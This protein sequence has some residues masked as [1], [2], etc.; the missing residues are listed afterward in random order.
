M[1]NKKVLIEYG[2]TLLI[3]LLLFSAVGLLLRAMLFEP[4]K[5]FESVGAFLGAEPAAGSTAVGETELI[6]SAA[7][8]CYVLVTTED[9]SHYAA[10]YDGANKEKLFSQ[11]SSYLGMALGSADAPE[12]ITESDFQQALEQSGVFFD[13]V[14]PQPLSAVASW[15][16]TDL[17]GDAGEHSA[18]RL[19]L[20]S[21]KDVLC[22]YYIDESDYAI[23]R[24]NTA[25]SFSSLAVK[26]SEMPIGSSALA[27]ELGEAFQSLDPYFIFSEESTQLRAMTATN[28]LSGG[29]SSQELLNLFKMNS[30]TT[31][32]LIDSDG[33]SVYVDGERS[34]QVDVSG[35][36]SYSVTEGVGI[37]IPR[38]GG[39]LEL[40]DCIALVNS[41]AQ[42]SIGAT[43]SEA[44]IGLTGVSNSAIPSSCTLYFGYFIDGIPVE[45]SGGANAV[46]AQI[47]SGSVTRL[48]MVYRSYTHTGEAIIPL[49]EKQACAIAGASGGEPLLRYEDRADGMGAAWV[50]N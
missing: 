9:G 29:F 15:L 36:L 20:G 21:N 16:G 50:I 8:P 33:A 25:L 34:L 4:S 11:F 35:K 41:I 6:T 24:C 45:L 1:K 7:V 48:D 10:K 30:R 42:Q 18:R 39:G 46:R 44:S 13:Y 22:L 38:S 28:P 12:Q 47:S 5:F 14:Y 17:S 49:P 43:C 32:E 19:Y 2:K 27:F 31:R 3:C 40:S 37:R 26:I 23:Y